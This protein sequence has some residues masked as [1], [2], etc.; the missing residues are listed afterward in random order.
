MALPQRG[1]IPV[2]AAGSTTGIRIGR[3]ED[4]SVQGMLNTQRRAGERA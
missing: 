1:K 4:W 2:A 3:D